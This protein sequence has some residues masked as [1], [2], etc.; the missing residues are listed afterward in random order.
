MEK[1]IFEYKSNT[2]LYNIEKDYFCIRSN[3]NVDG[4]GYSYY[5]VTDVNMIEILMFH[6]GKKG[7]L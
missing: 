2:Y 6:L 4:G 3:A 7:L 1:I 5:N